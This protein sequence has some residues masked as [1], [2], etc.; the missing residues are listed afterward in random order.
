MTGVRKC[1]KWG[2]GTVI[3]AAH[4]VLKYFSGIWGA[5]VLDGRAM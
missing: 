4:F 2:A 1:E 3:G 5:D